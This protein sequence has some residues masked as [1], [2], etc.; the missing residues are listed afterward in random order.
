MGAHPHQH[1]PEAEVLADR[2]RDPVE[3]RHQLGVAAQPSENLEHLVQL[4]GPH[5]VALELIGNPLRELL[6]LLLQCLDLLLELA[7]LRVVGRR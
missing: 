3:M 6:V 7:H 2:L 5:P 4:L 1:D